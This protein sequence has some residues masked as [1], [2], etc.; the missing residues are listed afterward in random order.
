MGWLWCD[1]Q[2]LCRYFDIEVREVVER[3]V[4]SLQYKEVTAA[5]YA[6]RTF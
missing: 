6:L 2:K 1:F 4:E 3:K 5:S